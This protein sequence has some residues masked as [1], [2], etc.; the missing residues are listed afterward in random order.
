MSALVQKTEIMKKQRYTYTDYYNWDESVG[1]CE[2]IDGIIYAMA[3]PT[4]AHQTVILNLGAEMHSFFKGKKCRPYIAPFD[5]RLNPT[6]LDDT[7]VQPDVMVICDPKK[8]SDGKACKGAPDF[9][10]EVSSPST[11]KHD[12]Q[13]KF[14]K[15]EQSG[16]M[17]YWLVDPVAHTIETFALENGSLI[18]REFVDTADETIKSAIFE[19]ME[20]KLSDIFANTLSPTEHLREPPE[21]LRNNA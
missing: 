8:T 3:A 12:R 13:R 19:D 16:V 17:E 4:E 2:L 14:K 9:V 5:V 7:V 11:S 10:V 21:E 6:G 15:Y 1:R 20:L 18:Q